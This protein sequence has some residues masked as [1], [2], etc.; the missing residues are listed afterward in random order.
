[1]DRIEDI[2]ERQ[3]TH[4]RKMLAMM[5]TGGIS[6]RSQ[7]RDVTAETADE[8]RVLEAELSAELDRHR[9]RNP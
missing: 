4:L 6:M 8:Y 5:S 3:L 2:L 7:G 1:M 9:M